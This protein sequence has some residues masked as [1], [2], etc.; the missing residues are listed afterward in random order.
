M[1]TAELLRCWPSE[2]A[3]ADCIKTDA[4]ASSE[5]VSLA[6]HQPMTFEKRAVAS[7]GV[8]ILGRCD[9]HELLREFLTKTLPEGRMILPIVGESGV[10][11]SHVVRWIYTQ[12]QRLSDPDRRLVIR[13]PKGMSLKGILG[14][15]LD[16]TPSSGLEKYRREIERA[17]DAIDP[18]RAAG[19]LCEDLAQTL[20]EMFEQAQQQL[21]EN[22]T[23]AGAREIE[24]FCRRDM[25]PALF[26]NQYL[27]DMHFVRDSEGSA[28]P[29]RRLIEHLT[30][31][32]G[33]GLED[34][35]KHVFVDDDLSFGQHVD[36]KQLGPAERNAVQKLERPERRHTAVR[37]LNEAL[38]GAK[39]RLLRT[40]PAITELFDGVRRELLAE[41][42]EL[43]LLIEDFAVLSGLQGQLLQIVIKEAVRD[44]QQELC[45]M[46]TALAYT[47]GYHIPET[48]RTRAG[49]EYF[50]PNNPGDEQDT[51][52][53]IERFVGA[54]LN[55][56]RLGRKRL[57]D[58]YHS[59]VDN[60]KKWIPSF[61]AGLEPGDLAILEAFGRSPDGYWLFPFNS[62]AIR[63][64]AREA[65]GHDG[66]VDYNPRFIIRL[67]IDRVLRCRDDFVRGDFP[68]QSLGSLKLAAR[69]TTELQQR[70][71]QTEIQRY[72]RFLIYWAEQPDDIHDVVEIDELVFRAF[73]LDRALLLQNQPVRPPAPPT[74]SHVPTTTTAPIDKSRDSRER[75]FEEDLERW[76]TGVRM[77]Q[78]RSRDLRRWVAAAISDAV[79][80]DWYIF[81]QQKDARLE[82]WR[83]SIYIPNAQGNQGK[84]VDESAL[85]VCTEAEL[86]DDV[87]SAQVIT[88]LAAV[89]RAYEIH[90]GSLDYDGADEDF[91]RYAAFVAP[92]MESARRWVMARPLRVLW[93]PVPTLVQGLLIGALALGLSDNDNRTDASIPI[94]ALF[95]VVP[96]P[97][98]TAPGAVAGEGEVEEFRD[99]LRQCRGSAREDAISWRSLLLDLVGARQG[100][101]QQVYAIDV[102]RLKSAVD[103]VTTNWEFATDMPTR[104]VG[105]A[106]FEH[107]KNLFSELRRLSRV[108]E[109][110]R[111]R[112]IAWRRDSLEWFGEPVDKKEV[113]FELRKTLD[114]ITLIGLSGEL[115]LPEILKLIEDFSSSSVEDVLQAVENVEHSADRGTV[116]S[117]IGRYYEPIVDLCERLRKRFDELMRRADHELQVNLRAIGT[118]PVGAAVKELVNELDRATKLVEALSS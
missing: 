105:P 11:K 26:R 6:V 85:A 115:S 118:D 73:G 19:Q 93:N 8:R 113:A 50:I 97:Q 40:D 106:A 52:K 30:E 87:K 59:E 64:F 44:G 75:G 45:T 112:L 15:I 77:A 4:E 33:A 51:L 17:Q 81:R 1:S 116:L 82:D 99:R 29:A 88:T 31:S 65:S 107:V 13:I 76:R 34:D 58:A 104:V 53:R 20:Q 110:E 28:G 5:A 60:S 54:Y 69:L 32:R 42:K 47:T 70:V 102:Q 95:A 2:E 74:D 3:V 61:E 101:G 98:D 79:D 7:E 83:D 12:L 71:P 23:N 63:T 57:E 108:V 10:G 72:S 66:H 35:R 90:R 84:S 92:R 36:L 111:Q 22:P 37:I 55:A 89:Y 78:D 68:P 14:L 91:P 48:V 16:S 109:R 56:T 38:D 18:S 41:D 62:Q 100:R 27:R 21:L 46:R 80:W 114:A 96:E 24:A 86:G 9:E 117:V 43:I 94:E 67:V 39:Q 49:I 103:T 25:L